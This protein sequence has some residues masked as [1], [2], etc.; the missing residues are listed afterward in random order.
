MIAF[1]I[2]GA[3]GRLLV[4]DELITLVRFLLERSSDCFS[5]QVLFNFCGSCWR[6][7]MI[8]FAGGIR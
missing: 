3:I 6:D 5:K 7:Q 8:G 4:E 2:A 1:P